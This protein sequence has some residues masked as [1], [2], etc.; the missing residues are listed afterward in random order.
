MRFLTLIF[1]LSAS[2]LWAATEVSVPVTINAGGPFFSSSFA[3]PPNTTGTMRIE[4]PCDPL[5]DLQIGFM[6]SSDKGSTWSCDMTTTP[7]G[8]FVR[9]PGTCT[10]S[11]M[12]ATWTRYDA[13]GEKVPM[14]SKNLIR[15]GYISNLTKSVTIK[16]TWDPS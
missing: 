13:K 8:G 7:C 5:W 11:M 9:T 2:L 1:L 16:A 14:S 15:I 12:V 6:Q 3:I 10:G 4:I